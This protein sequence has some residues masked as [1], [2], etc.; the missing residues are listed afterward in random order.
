MDADWVDIRE[1][2]INMGCLGTVVDIGLQLVS[3]PRP[4]IALLATMEKCHV[5]NL[6][7]SESGLKG[8]K[9]ESETP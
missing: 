9:I 1:G 6:K 2:V 5:P 8:L 3:G 4:E 7:S